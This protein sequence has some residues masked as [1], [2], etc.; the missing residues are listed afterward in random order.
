MSTSAQLQST[1]QA[2]SLPLDVSVWMFFGCVVGGL[3]VGVA[4]CCLLVWRV[5]DSFIVSPAYTKPKKT[6]H[7]NTHTHTHTHIHTLRQ[8]ATPSTPRLQTRVE[9]HFW[10]AAHQLSV[11]YCGTQ[12]C[13]RPSRPVTPAVIAARLSWTVVNATNDTNFG[14]AVLK[15]LLVIHPGK[16]AGNKDSIVMTSNERP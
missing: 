1:M 8:L 13:N 15:I 12:L 11:V 7:D 6:K 16:K 9:I 5:V 4:Q 10:V 3:V 14:R 2:R